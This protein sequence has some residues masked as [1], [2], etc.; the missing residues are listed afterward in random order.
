M[1]RSAAMM[2]LAFML[3]S[4]AIYADDVDPVI[5]GNSS[6]DRIAAQAQ[7][8]MTQQQQVLAQRLQALSAAM[9]AQNPDVPIVVQQAP[10]PVQPAQPAPVTAPAQATPPV[11]TTPSATGLRPSSQNNNSRG[12]WDYGF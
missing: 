2:G 5:Q 10:T 12:K 6:A 9:Q 1:K 11:A 3:C 4:A 8:N 7:A